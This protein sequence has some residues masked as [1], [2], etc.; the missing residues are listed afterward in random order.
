MTSKYKKGKY[1]QVLGLTFCFL[2]MLLSK[3]GAS[4]ELDFLSKNVEN[5]PVRILSIDGGG[6]RGIIPLTFL[7]WLETETQKRSYEMFSIVGGT[8]AG[9]MIAAAITQPANPDE[10]FHNWYPKYK[11]DDLINLFL[12]EKCNIFRKNESYL[13][14]ILKP[15]YDSSSLDQVMDRYYGKTTFDKSLIPT[16]TVSFDVWARKLKIFKSWDKKEIYFTKDVVRSS[17]AAPIL[18]SA[19]SVAPLK[20]PSTLYSTY[21]DGAILA[22]NPTAH[23]LAEAKAL[24]PKS[25]TFEVVSLG[26]G[27]NEDSISSRVYKV[28]RSP[29]KLRDH[30]LEACLIR[31]QSAP[32]EASMEK[33]P[34]I[35]FNL[36]FNPVLDSD[37][38]ALDDI[39]EDTFTHLRNL[40]T[41]YIH[42]NA[43][44]FKT[45]VKRLKET[46]P[47]SPPL[48]G[49]I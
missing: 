6:V 26:T 37:Y 42:E 30:V 31:G 48:H 1:L 9:S 35:N 47:A 49:S 27:L 14:G 4:T 23:L 28:M 29:Y 33:D 20:G 5:C 18:F 3:T 44:Q 21:I 16:A 22:T 11:A 10:D 43:D 24:Y 38:L 2:M 8:S 13:S 32:V 17:A 12:N 7:S 15:L 36:R 45:L 46:Q 25:K 41:R 40:T 19:H 39:R 34:D